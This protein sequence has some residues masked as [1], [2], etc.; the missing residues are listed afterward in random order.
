MEK[1]LE[2]NRENGETTLKT[3]KTE[4]AKGDSALGDSTK[5]TVAKKSVSKAGEKESKAAKA[6]V[7][8]ALKKKKSEEL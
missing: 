7:E 5:R 4:S 8:T 6:R 3:V 2:K 1:E